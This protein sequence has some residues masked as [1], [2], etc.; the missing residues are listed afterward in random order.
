[1]FSIYEVLFFSLH[2]PLTEGAD[3]SSD[4]EGEEPV[5]TDCTQ[6]PQTKFLR[7][8]LELLSSLF[9]FALIHSMTAK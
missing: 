7:D 9:L 3:Y 1:M 6:E 5:D 8:S 4:R 2:I